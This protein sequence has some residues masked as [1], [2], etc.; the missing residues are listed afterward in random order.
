MKAIILGILGALFFASIPYGLVGFIGLILVW[1]MRNNDHGLVLVLLFGGIAWN[2]MF[3]FLSYLVA[4]HISFPSS[5]LALSMIGRIGLFLS[6]AIAI[7]IFRI[8][9]KEMND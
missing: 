5:Y 2:G 7:W 6:T 4:P 1:D 9:R 8:K 3:Y